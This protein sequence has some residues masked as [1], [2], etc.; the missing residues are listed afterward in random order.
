M[1][2]NI[3]DFYFDYKPDHCHKPEKPNFTPTEQA[4]FTL[5]QVRDM[6]EQLAAFREALEK[7]VNILCKQL[8]NDNVTFK[9]TIANSHNDFVKAVNE[10]TTKFENGMNAAYSLMQENFN[11]YKSEIDLQL[12][13]LET[14]KTNHANRIKALEDSMGVNG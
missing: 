11:E 6:L 2:P 7:H 9:D 3:Y 5:A 13:E 10:E 14:A 4:E 1:I 8:T 12:S